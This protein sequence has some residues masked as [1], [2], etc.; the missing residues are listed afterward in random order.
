M[1]KTLIAIL[2]LAA[3][4]AGCSRE[5][6]PEQ[7]AQKL[8]SIPLTLS[9][10]MPG[11]KTYIEATPD[12]WRPYWQ[13]G[14]TLT[15]VL[16]DDLSKQFSFANQAE[17]GTTGMF[18][19]TIEASPGKQDIL[20]YYPKSIKDGRAENVFKFKLPAVQNVPSLQTFD[21]ACDLLVADPLTVTVEEGPSIQTGDK[22]HFNRIFAIARI[23]VND[24]TSD[25][26]LAGKTIRSVTLTS[27][28]SILT[29]RAGVIIGEG[30]TIDNWE[31]KSSQNYVTA[32]YEG[33]DWK[34]D[35]TNGVF[36]V[37]NPVTLASGTTLTLDVETDDEEL[38]VS[39]AVQL[40]AP[41]ALEPGT[42]PTLK[43]KIQDANVQ[44]K[45][46]VIN[47]TWDFSTPEWQAELAKQAPSANGTNQAGW[48]VSF[49]GLTYTS[50]SKNGKWS[51]DGYIQPNGAGSAS[52]RVF[53]FTAPADGKLTVTASTPTKDAVRNVCV[54]KADSQQVPLDGSKGDLVFN[55]KAGTVN[56]W[57]D[58]GIRFF[59]FVYVSSASGEDPQDPEDPEEAADLECTNP[60]AVGTVDPTVMYGYAEADGV[61]GGEGATGPNILHFDT[62]KALQTWL[63]ARTKSEKAG[64]HSPRIIWLS[65]TF[66]PDDGR[67]FS[68]A[69]PWFDIKDVSNLSF[70]GTDSFVMDR[71]GFFAVR[72]SNII[73]RN[74]NF[75]QPKANNGAD[76]LSL[77]ECDGIWIDHCTFT[78]LNQTKDYE[79]GST[80][81]THASKNVTV[82]WCHYI[83]TQKSCLVGHS[84]SA[85]GDAAITATF[86]H[87]WFDVSSSRHPRV[88]F[89]TVHVY[90][91]LFDGCTTYGVGSAYGAKVLV[92]YN[93]F[94]AVQLPTDICTYPAKE[95]NE[96]NL[97]GSVAGY[98]YPTENVYVN[99]PAKAK[100]PYPLS[101]VKYTSYNG[102]TI[103]PLTYSDFKP[104]YDYIVTAAADVP[105]VVKANS[106]YGKLGWTEAPVA[107]NNGGIS[108]YTGSGD[109]PE[110]PDPDDPDTPPAG[111]AEGWSWT[112]NNSTATYSISE[113]KLSISATGK[114]E[115]SAQGFGVAHRE[116]TGDF[117][118]TVKL[119]SFTPAKES[120][121]GVAGLIVISGEAS[122]SADNLIYAICGKGDK[123]YRRFRSATGG[124]SS[125][126]EMK[127]PDTSGGYT[128]LKIVR[129][130]STIKTCYSLDGGET[131]GGVSSLDFTGIPDTVRIGVAC[132][133][134]DNSK[135]GTAV[136]SDFIVNGTTIAF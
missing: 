70:Y 46:D 14:D 54:T 16:S 22:L 68:E 124:K 44:N 130:G 32:A 76:A 25:G 91:N 28:S 7:N 42:I 126:S 90:N 23:V 63:L 27:S 50:G 40:S 48:S 102:S 106:G 15:V 129:E 114:W 112:I 73:F 34:A 96:S 5:M 41:I 10:E 9:A 127:A 62:G 81:I 113:G 87:N 85:T 11:T 17:D 104:A 97:Q 57:P 69:H 79:D 109:D 43:F 128:V 82:S 133:S 115:S 75:R 49:A 103:T 123:F 65:G 24:A 59:K 37:V 60:P 80:D 107:V 119:V 86:H 122:A 29:G 134:S 71:I 118:A 100:D 51:T 12:G 67:D 13:Q 21:P 89:G 19:G 116:V 72:A 18:S 66:G 136:F 78:S 52:E 135:Q 53:T 83:K 47:Y 20:A 39:R 120:N 108:E 117:T 30:G 131:F 55:V 84:N 2:A 95:S 26:K 88:R 61:T 92:E 36:V 8:L 74:I 99:R 6:S 33:S 121:Q 105:S 101:N 93:Y 111:F 4:A 64:D 38:F 45:N 56:V 77:Q 31:A 132:N 35:G 58:A 3:M 125:S 94:D 1:K 98:L 110:D